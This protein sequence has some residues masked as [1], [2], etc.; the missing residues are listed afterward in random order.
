MAKSGAYQFYIN[1]SNKLVGNWN[2]GDRITSTTSVNNGKWHYVAVV[3]NSGTASLYIDGVLDATATGQPTPV[4]NT[5]NFSIGAMWSNKSAISS[6]FSGDIDEIR[7][8]NSALTAAQ[9]RYIMNQEIEK[10]VR[11]RMEKPFLTPLPKTILQAFRG[12]IFRLIMT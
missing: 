8:W 4:S 10:M 12:I 6:V 7:I 11:I 9:I 2:G 3:F 1:G 5:A